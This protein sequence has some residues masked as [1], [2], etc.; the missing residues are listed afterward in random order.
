MTIELPA[1]LSDIHFWLGFL[2]GYAPQ[3]LITVI[4]LLQHRSRHY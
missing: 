1:L 3:A 4:I 2:P